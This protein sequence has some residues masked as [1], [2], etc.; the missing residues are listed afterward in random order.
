LKELPLPSYTVNAVSSK[1][2]TKD[3][4]TKDPDKCAAAKKRYLRDA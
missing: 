4:Y 2:D 1:A 3:K